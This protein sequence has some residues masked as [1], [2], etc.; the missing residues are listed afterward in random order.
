MN[1]KEQKQSELERLAQDM[2]NI[3][4]EEIEKAVDSELKDIIESLTSGGIVHTSKLFRDGIELHAKRIRTFFDLR[5]QIDREVF[6]S[7]QPI[8]TD[9]DIKILL[10]HLKDIAEPQKKAILSPIEPWLSKIGGES[11][12]L[13]A[14]NTKV[15]S[16]LNQIQRELRIEKDKNILLRKEEIEKKPSKP[17]AIQRFETLLKSIEN[18]KLKEILL[19]DYGHAYYCSEKKLWK[20]CVALCGGIIEGVLA[21]E[22]SIEGKFEVKI[23]E[24]IKRG[25][26]SEDIG[27]KLA[28]VVRLLRNYVHIE[29][30]IKKG[31]SIDGNDA[32]LSFTIVAKIFI[33]IE[34]HKEKQM[35]KHKS[36]V[37]K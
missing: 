19:R 8:K 14:I 7:N 33:Q 25:I 3:E 31:G 30:E 18:E 22:F 24:A 9:D 11:K 36:L 2:F 35:K 28:H 32:I 4:R 20:P 23:K 29:K 1:K 26:I 27:G 37:S 13:G 16:I 5:M 17:P 10:K 21:V 15:D 12:F 34:K 6:L